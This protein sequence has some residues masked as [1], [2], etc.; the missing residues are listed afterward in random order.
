[1]VTAEAIGTALAELG[2]E[3]C[4]GVVGSGNFQVTIAMQAAGAR[5]VPARHESGAVTAADAYARLSG[6]VGLCTVH[7]G[8]GLTNAVT[9]LAEAA[10][11][12]TPMLVMAGDTAAGASHSN[13]RMDQGGLAESVGALSEA[14]GS[15]ATAVDDV[16]RAWRRA[17][18]ERLPVV[19]S[20]PIDVQAAECPEP[21]AFAAPSRP[22]AAP[23]DAESVDAAAGILARSRRPLLIA[24][25]GA[26]LAGARKP[27]EHL[28]R[29]SGAL[30]A[31][32]AV[33]N[34]LFAGHAYDLGI[35]G[36][37]ATPLAAEL[38]PKA[39]VIV[40]LGA[41]LNMWTTRRGRLLGEGARLLQ[42]DVE[43]EAIGLH[44]PADVALVGDAALTARALLDAVGHGAQ[45]TWRTPE[46]AAEI[47]RRRW[48]DEPYTD[49]SGDG[50]IDPRTLAIAL[51]DL[52]PAE[53][54]FACDG[55]HFMGWLPMYCRV[56]DEQGMVFTQ[57]FQAIGQ[58]FATAVGAAVARPDRLVVCGV[59]DGG[60]LM[61]VS[62]LETIARLGLPVLV[63]VFNDA[64][65]GA[66]VHHFG[67]D[68]FP[69]DTVRFPDTDF[70]ALGRAHGMEAL[71][72]RT[73]ADLAPLREW[74]EWRQ[75]PLLLDAKVVPTVVGEWLPEAFGH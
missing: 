30:L 65:Y 39:D 7:Q 33:A 9:G 53:R 45:E 42:V 59:G 22:A 28:A 63:V 50:R 27:I 18:T 47:A 6:R 29:A 64:A 38:I 52:L 34:G 73:P 40:S 1:M 4:F 69:L 2:V 16:A 31:T 12:R 21:A 68:G 70:A 46:L 13:F 20:M 55:G 49:A 35:S 23:A 75:R 72:V 36:G 5:F 61:G 58:G 62:E 15:A 41:S 10:K 51:D 14:L 71:T 74:L 19:V 8:P 57:G 44:R 54:L 67:P 60:A 32:S 48:R 66:E 56:P 24:G 43:S 3:V 17:L 11:S 26:V 37:F 25:R